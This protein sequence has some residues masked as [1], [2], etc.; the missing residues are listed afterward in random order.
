MLRR[1]E[2]VCRY[3]LHNFALTIHLPAC[4]SLYPREYRAY[5]IVIS[6]RYSYEMI[7]SPFVQPVSCTRIVMHRNQ[8]FLQSAFQ[9]AVE[10]PGYNYGRDTGWTQPGNHS[11][12]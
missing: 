9:V 1:W 2:T 5:I 4:C 8:G 6:V 12:L 3:I 11:Q 7:N 10:A